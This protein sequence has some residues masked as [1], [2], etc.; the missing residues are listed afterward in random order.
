MSGLPAGPPQRGRRGGTGVWEEQRVLAG[1]CLC[2][3][4]HCMAAWLVWGTQGR[5]DVRAKRG[6]G[7]H[8]KRPGGAELGR[9]SRFTRDLIYSDDQRMTQRDQ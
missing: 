7:R 1:R 5:P 3:L 6:G 9:V 8:F 2:L 4:W